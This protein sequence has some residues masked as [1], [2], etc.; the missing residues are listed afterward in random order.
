MNIHERLAILRERLTRPATLTRAAVAVAIA[1]GFVLAS[2]AIEPEDSRAA[3]DAAPGFAG[4]APAADRVSLGAL[5]GNGHCVHIHATPDGPRFSV[6]DARG[7][8]MGEGLTAEEMATRFPD[9]ELPS[10]L[11]DA[12]LH[13]GSH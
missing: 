4:P 5:V 8:L 1:L 9:I 3:G 2:T 7:V 10:M 12:I 13:A 6:T 11:A